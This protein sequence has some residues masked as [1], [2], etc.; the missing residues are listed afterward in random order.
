MMGAKQSLKSNLQN[1]IMIILE[2]VKSWDP[3]LRN[4]N[5]LKGSLSIEN[6]NLLEKKFLKMPKSSAIDVHLIQILVKPKELF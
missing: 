4:P 1:S 2:F 6:L 5:S 3:M